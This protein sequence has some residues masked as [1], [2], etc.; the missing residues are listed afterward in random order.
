MF[1]HHLS[2]VKSAETQYQ[3]RIKREAQEARQKEKEDARGQYTTAEFS[4]SLLNDSVIPT[5][6]NQNKK[7]E[8]PE[9]SQEEK[10]KKIELKQ[11]ELGNL[12]MNLRNVV[13]ADIMVYEGENNH[14]EFKEDV[15][16]APQHNLIRD[17]IVIG[18]MNDEI[19]IHTNVM[20]EDARKILLSQTS[21]CV[22]SKEIV[23]YAINKFKDKISEYIAINKV[24]NN[25]LPTEESV[26]KK[27]LKEALTDTSLLRILS[28][29]I[30]ECEKMLSVYRLNSSTQQPSTSM[31]PT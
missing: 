20:L 15:S 2:F 11:V 23:R 8:F 27:I 4:E 9:I 29:A 18:L 3:N 12:N 14:D 26:R 30:T 17:E 31:R 10:I 28:D 13:T 16:F 22:D 21:H 1:S 24:I 6:F 19:I 7:R 25:G 5:L